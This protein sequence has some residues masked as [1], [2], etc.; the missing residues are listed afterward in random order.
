MIENFSDKYP[1]NQFIQL[2]KNDVDYFASSLYDLIQN[3]YSNIGGHIEFS[4]V[5]SFKNTDLNFWIAS[6]IDDDPNADVVIGGKYTEQGIKITLGGQDGSRL[7]IATMISKIKDLM[8]QKGFYTEM[9]EELARKV[10]LQ[11]IEDFH[12][13]SKVLENKELVNLG[14]GIYERK[15]GGKWKRK[16][17]VGIPSITNS[18][19][20]FADGGR[21]EKM[22]ESGVVELKM[23]DTTPEHA[24]EYGLNANN[25]LYIQRIFVNENDR[26]KGLGKEVLQ[27]VDKYAKDNGHD[28]IFG[29]IEQKANPSRVKILLEK[30]D[31]TTIVGNNDFYKFVGK[32]SEGGT[33]TSKFKAPNGKP[34]NLTKEQWEL[35]RT[36]QFKAWFGDWENDSKNASKV[37]DEN[38]EPLVVYHASP[39]KFNVFQKQEKAYFFSKNK[40]NAKYFVK[41]FKNKKLSI[42]SISSQYSVKWNATCVVFFYFS[43][44]KCFIIFSPISLEW[45]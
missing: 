22:I 37:V 9:D 28:L 25:P 21:I 3:A 23:Y 42:F 36:P 34:S 2:N 18:D 4:S 6:D 15:I 38:G 5:D 10:K 44:F 24:K 7:S 8:K 19:I 45:I 20:E 35:V 31:Y 27:Y 33:T 32:F 39:E 40:D 43:I 11:P 29:H 12:V 1:K 30:N 16:V 17:L 41:S 13:I 14:N 26:N